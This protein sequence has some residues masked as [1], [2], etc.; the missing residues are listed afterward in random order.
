[1]RTPKEWADVCE[2]ISAG[3]VPDS[4]KRSTFASG[5]EYRRLYLQPLKD[6]VSLWHDGAVVVDIGSGNGR[7]AMVLC[8]EPITYHGLEI[9]KGSVEFCRMAFR[10]HLNFH[11]HH[12]DIHNGHYNGRGAMQPESATFPLP[13]ESADLVLAS[14][15]FSHLTPLAAVSRYLSEV[16]RIL[17][18]GGKFYSTWYRSPPNDVSSGEVRT[19]YP[20]EAIRAALA[21]FRWILDEEGT[22]RGRG[23]QWRILVKKA[24]VEEGAL[25]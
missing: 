8:E 2:Q 25:E 3:Y 12:L 1:M 21:G 13:D 16:H 20:E 18:P 24:I 4:G 10:D 15:L 23:D 5:Q 19:V 14:S 17:K 7:L 6:A 11:F 9:I 22:T